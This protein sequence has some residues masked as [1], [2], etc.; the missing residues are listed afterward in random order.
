[1]MRAE[2]T[3]ITPLFSR[4]AYEDL[5]EIRPASIRGQL[6]HWFRLLGGSA[7]DERGVFGSVHK[8]FGGHDLVPAAS[9]LVVRVA[10]LAAPDAAA[11]WLPTLPH[12]PG[13]QNP[14]N[15]PNAPRGALPAGTRFTL[16]VLERLGGL[17]PELRAFAERTVHAWLLAGALGL[18]ATRGG[19]AFHWSEAPTDLRSFWHRLSGLFQDAPVSFDVLDRVFPNAEDARKVITETIAHP[20][21]ADLAYPLGAVRQGNSDPAPGRKTSPL[22]LT[23][24]RFADGNRI[25]ALW[26][27]RGTVTGNTRAHLR[28]AIKRLAN[29]TSQSRPTEIG[30]LL[31]ASKLP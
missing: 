8:D 29:G 7:A 12:K 28:D 21:L 10:G 1:M 9:R 24:R 22:R 11:Q 14:R 16:V 20:A 5:P 2:L 30:R 3:F 18:R 4:G 26:D 6:H 15:A 19:G 23:V 27:E 25:L 13:G 31:A 17:S